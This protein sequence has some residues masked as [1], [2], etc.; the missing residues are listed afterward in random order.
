MYVSATAVRCE[1]PGRVPAG[2]TTVTASNDGEAFTIS[3]LVGKAVQ[4]MATESALWTA[5]TPGY[6]ANADNVCN[7]L[8]NAN[9][10][11]VSFGG[12]FCPECAQPE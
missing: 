12:W 2:A 10:A 3:E 9:D 4:H 5:G 1:T 6:G 8:D 11:E 7:H